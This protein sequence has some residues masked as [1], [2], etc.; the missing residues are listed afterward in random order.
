M[1]RAKNGLGRKTHGEEQM[2]S[3]VN[4]KYQISVGIFGSVLLRYCPCWPPRAGNVNVQHLDDLFP[5]LRSGSTLTC[6]CSDNALACLN[7]LVTDALALVPD[8][9]AYMRQIKN[10]EVF[11]FCAIPQVGAST[12]L[13]FL[14]LPKYCNLL[15]VYSLQ[16]YSGKRPKI[17]LTYNTE[18]NTCPPTTK[19]VPN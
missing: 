5:Y 4:C 7:E 8:C 15:S 13:V 3:R 16:A 11:R 9:L 12:R 2:L 1:S 6:A 19:L 14:D 18:R 17:Q 10:P